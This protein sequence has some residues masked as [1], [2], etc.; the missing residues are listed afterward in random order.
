MKHIKKI[1]SFWSIAI[2][3]TQSTLL[4][5]TYWKWQ[6]INMYNVQFPT[7][8]EWGLTTLSYEAEG[9]SKTSTWYAWENH[10][11]NNNNQPFTK[12]RS[13]KAAAHSENYKDDVRLMKEMGITT[14]CFSI[15]WSRVE[16]EQGRFDETVLQYYTD[17]CDE[18]TKNNISITAILKDYCDPLWWGYL[19]GFEDE[20]N[21][22]LFERYCLKMYQLLGTRV[23]RWITFWAP[24]NY[25]VLGYLIGTTP[26]GVR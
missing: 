19:G 8:F 10:V 5:T 3:L 20:K 7:S 11:G 25:A 6:N 21:I 9:Y 22:H 18:L 26:P 4:A 13:G 16:P 2:L 14:Y 24:E 15:D 12:T 1:L 17:L 23:N